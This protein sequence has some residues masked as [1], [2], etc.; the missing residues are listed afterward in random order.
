MHELPEI[1]RYIDA[2]LEAMRTHA[3]E[4]YVPVIRIL[5]AGRP[6]PLE[7]AAYE[8]PEK[9]GWVFL[10]GARTGEAEDANPAEGHPDDVFLFVNE[11]SIHGVEL[12]FRRTRRA[13]IGFPTYSVT[14]SSDA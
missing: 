1:R 13:R 14:P 5:V 6:E 9:A 4:G 10:A 7:V 8:R 11:A 2:N 12:V 3:P